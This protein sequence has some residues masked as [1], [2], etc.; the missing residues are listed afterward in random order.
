MGYFEGL[1]VAVTGAGSGIGRELAR[2]LAS[3]GAHLALSDSHEGSVQATAKLCA[4]G[5]G[6]VSVAVVDVADRE[7][8]LAHAHEMATRF[9]R[10]DA[11]INNAGILFAGDV[12]DTSFEDY[13][14]VLD[15]D[16]WGVVNGT[17]AFLPYVMQSGHGHVVNVS[18]AFGLMAAPSYSAY[19]AAKFAVRGFT[20]SLRQEM[21]LGGH[22]VRVTCVHPG[23]VR[24][25]IARTARHASGVDGSA[26]AAVFEQRIARTEPSVAAR[27][28]LR[29][30]ERGLPRVLIGPDARLVD[31]V[32]RV[33]GARYQSLISMRTR[34]SRGG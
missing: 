8:L 7:S 31:L 3:S 20:E 23:G 4:A 33:A 1:V 14:R 30:V 11:V 27:T 17:K 19:N 32:T 13:E 18:S 21:L 24:T 6:E 16:F 25:I 2:R 9:G 29:G 22:G 5:P 34:F 26:I 10:V 28:I 12:I 15:V